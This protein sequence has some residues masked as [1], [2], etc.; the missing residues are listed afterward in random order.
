MHASIAPAMPPATTAL[1]GCCF[2]PDP[3]TAGIGGY[4][5]G[6]AKIVG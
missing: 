1:P 4:G 5:V 3:P 2:L 6:A